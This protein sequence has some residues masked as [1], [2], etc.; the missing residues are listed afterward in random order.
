MVAVEGEVEPVDE[1][2]PT[3]TATSVT[4]DAPWLPHA[5]TCNTCEP[6]VDETAALTDVL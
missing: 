2:E 1:L 3:E 6:V 4:H 5:L